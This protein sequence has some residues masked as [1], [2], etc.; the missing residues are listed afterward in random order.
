MF[1]D[2]TVNHILLNITEKK[3]LDFE[4][5]GRW[6]K[7]RFTRKREVLEEAKRIALV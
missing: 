4:V 1:N 7:A 6:N 3:D 5:G 2:A